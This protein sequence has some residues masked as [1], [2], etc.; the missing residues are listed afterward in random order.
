MEKYG[1]FA[2]QYDESRQNDIWRNLFC[3]PRSMDLKALL[4]LMLEQT[5]ED[6]VYN[7]D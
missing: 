5:G 3:L 4:S 2:P 1:I 6:D 7:R